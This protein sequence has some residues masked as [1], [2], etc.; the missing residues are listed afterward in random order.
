MPPGASWGPPGSSWE[1]L[2]DLLGPSEEPLGSFLG[3]DSA[4]SATGA[5]QG[6]GGMTA[7]PLNLVWRGNGKRI[8]FLMLVAYCHMLIYAVNAVLFC[9]LVPSA[10]ICSHLP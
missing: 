9:Y 10:A 8:Q 3:K 6:V 5:P 1:P 4:R 7:Q 2:G